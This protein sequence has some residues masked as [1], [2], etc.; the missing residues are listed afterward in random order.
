MILIE[1]E[2]NCAVNSPD[3]G[4]QGAA[5]IAWCTALMNCVVLL[6]SF[7]SI[8]EAMSIGPCR[9]VIVTPRCLLS[10]TSSVS[11]ES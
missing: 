9:P 11:Q 1:S 6:S 10:L 3:C 7:E 4:L 8:I 5:L 2:S